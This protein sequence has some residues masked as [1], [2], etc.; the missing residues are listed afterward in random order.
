MNDKIR[1]LRNK[2][3]RA[4]IELRRYRDFSEE[5][6][7]IFIE[8]ED[9]MKNESDFVVVDILENQLLWVESLIELER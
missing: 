9:N 2:N 6:L 1:K 8:N 3:L 5:E 4:T 7:E